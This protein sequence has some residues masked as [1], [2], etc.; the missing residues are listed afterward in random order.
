MVVEYISIAVGIVLGVLFT[1]EVLSRTRRV[2]QDWTT[3]VTN[4]LV[5]AAIYGFLSV[6]ANFLGKGA[7]IDLGKDAEAA[8]IIQ[9]I[10]AGAAYV[11][12]WTLLRDRVRRR[13]KTRRELQVEGQSAGSAKTA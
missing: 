8:A 7:G 12:I 9:G 6:G 5:Q 4:T 11:I 3:A 10:G 1:L 13:W 2:G